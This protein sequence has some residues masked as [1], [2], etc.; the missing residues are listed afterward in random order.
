MIRRKID[1]LSSIRTV[2]NRVKSFRLRYLSKIIQRN[3]VSFLPLACSINLRTASVCEDDPFPVQSKEW[4]NSQSAS[5]HNLLEK[6][7]VQHYVKA[8]QDLYIQLN[9]KNDIIHDTINQDKKSANGNIIIKQI[10]VKQLG[11]EK[12][13]LQYNKIFFVWNFV[14]KWH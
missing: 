9:R 13:P 7:G 3:G 14:S 8:P 6:V 2:P 5:A 11:R 12:N 10:K 4:C 1:S